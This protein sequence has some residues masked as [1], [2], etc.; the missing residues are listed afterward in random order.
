MRYAL[1]RGEGFVLITG[2]PG[3]G[4]TTLIEDLLAGLDDA[5]ITGARLRDEAGYAFRSAAR[6]H[7]G[8]GSTEV[9][10]GLHHDLRWAGPATLDTP[11]GVDH[12]AHQD[13]RL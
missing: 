2:K 11:D 10:T 6:R 1:N 9:D 7:E 13:H 3:T 8:G 4:K 5:P 12:L